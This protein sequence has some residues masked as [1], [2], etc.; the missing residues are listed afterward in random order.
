[1]KQSSQTAGLLEAPR[2]L[3]HALSFASCRDGIG[4]RVTPFRNGCLLTLLVSLWSVAAWSAPPSHTPPAIGFNGSGVAITGLA[5]GGPAIVFSVDRGH[6]GAMEGYTRHDYRLSAADAAGNA[7]VIL[8]SVPQ[9]SLW[10]VV[11][12]TTGAYATA[13]PAGYAMRRL[14]FP[15]NALR[16]ASNAQLNRLRLKDEFLEVLWVR[17]GVGAWRASVGDGGLSDEDHAVDG[18]LSIVP[19]QMEPIGAAPPPPGHYL[20]N[21][22]FI[23]INPITMELLAIPEAQ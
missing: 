23:L 14:P 3:L 15:A 10:C 4:Y 17:P 1:M 16:G 18:H 21:D 12:L 20:P 13:A 7:R 2:P 6:R 22:T 9:I 5:P 8:P 11:D 19:K